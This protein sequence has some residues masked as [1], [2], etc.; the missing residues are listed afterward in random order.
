MIATH[1]TKR[2]AAPFSFEAR[3]VAMVIIQPKTK[4]NRGD[5]QTIEKRG[6]L[7][8]HEAGKEKDKAGRGASVE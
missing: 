4:K 1:A 7:K 5:Q 2:G 3:M 8:S 6:D